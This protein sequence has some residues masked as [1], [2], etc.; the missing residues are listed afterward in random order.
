MAVKQQPHLGCGTTID[1]IWMGMDKQP[2][3]HQR[4]CPQCRAARESLS[5]L[6]N[7]VASYRRVEGLH[8]ESVLPSRSVRDNILA[9]ARSEVRR[10]RRSVAMVTETG[11]VFIS[12]QALVDLVRV[13]TD[14][15]AGVRG[16]H[17]EL[18]MCSAEDPV[19]QQRDASG[20]LRRVLTA[21]TVRLSIK[22][23][24][25]IP[26]VTAQVRTRILTVLVNHVDVDPVSVDLVVEDVFDA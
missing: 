9:V 4:T 21:L 19:D 12:D 15:V 13:A 6:Q 5:T 22:Y 25:S 16:R 11:P 3:A 10:G 17:V 26:E 23:G 14:T 7:M 18:S 1:E 2:T 20:D 24:A 8:D